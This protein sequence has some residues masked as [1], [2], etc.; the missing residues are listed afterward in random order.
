MSLAFAVE[1]LAEC[2]DEMISLAEAHWH[3]TMQWQHGKQAFAPDFDRYNAY[4]V[5]GMAILFTVR[6]DGR[7]V[8]HG[9]MYICPSMH[10]QQIIA[11]E[12]A[13]FLLPEYRRGRNALRLYQFVEQECA[14][15]GAVEIMV[16]AKPDTGAARIL[17]HLGCTLVNYQYCKHLAPQDMKETA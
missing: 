7:M 2:W 10:T 8:G 15:R 12:D 1:P 6:D 9:L 14:K 5:A 17:E 16:T 13:M 3:E 4:E 11:T